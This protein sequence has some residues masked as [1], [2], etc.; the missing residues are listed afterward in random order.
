VDPSTIDD[1]VQHV[2]PLSQEVARAYRHAPEGNG[3]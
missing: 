1:W 3:P 2:A